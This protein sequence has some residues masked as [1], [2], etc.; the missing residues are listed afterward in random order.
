MDDLDQQSRAAWRGAIP[1]IVVLG[2]AAAYGG[3]FLV[4]AA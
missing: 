2:G 1:A 3:C 4:I